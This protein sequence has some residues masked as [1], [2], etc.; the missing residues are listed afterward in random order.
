LRGGFDLL[1]RKERADALAD[2]RE[3]CAVHLID[4]SPK[5]LRADEPSCEITAAN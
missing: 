5:S 4:F 3:E 2:L 1:S